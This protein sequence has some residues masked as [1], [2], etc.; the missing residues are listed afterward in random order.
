MVKLSKIFILVFVFTMVI[1]SFCL[2]QEI[3]IIAGAGP[4]TSVV[5][6]FVEKFS[7]R[8]AAKGYSFKV[9]P[10]SAKHAGG[11]KNSDKFIFGRT[12]RP[13]NDQEKSLGKDEIFL[14][15]VPIAFAIGS[16]A[17]ITSL[18][19]AQ[20]ETIFT[21]DDVTWK[22]FGGTDGK[23]INIGREPNEALC[24]SIKKDLPFFKNAKFQTIIKKDH[25][26]I[27][28]LGKAQGKFAIGF[29]A[30]PNFEKAS[31][32][33]IHVDGFS[34]GVRLGLVYDRKNSENPIVKGV[35]EFVASSEWQDAIQSLGLLIP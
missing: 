2:S 6:L 3:Q 28:L 31:I 35:K 12:G 9:P 21:S 33:T 30:K 15:R 23:I 13:L 4:S 25:Q 7:S 24:I 16:D 17:G 20:I 10:K 27:G 22:D 34:S 5:Q 14:A 19:L 32:S 26:V 1:A 8:P 29:G 11:I 18:T